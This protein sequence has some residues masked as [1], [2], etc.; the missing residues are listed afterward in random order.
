MW[1]EGLSC[2]VRRP[3]GRLGIQFSG[4]RESA[5][6]RHSSASETFQTVVSVST[7]WISA[8]VGLWLTTSTSTPPAKGEASGSWIFHEPPVLVGLLLRHVRH[9]L[10][11]ALPLLAGCESRPRAVEAFSG[12]G[13]NSCRRRLRLRAAVP[14]GDKGEMDEQ[15]EQ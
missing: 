14:T 6:G 5:A 2:L 12:S 10:F 8:T 13:R 4:R 1:T 9:H 15:G 11:E 7:G 3:P